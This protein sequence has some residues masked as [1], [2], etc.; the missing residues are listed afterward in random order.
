MGRDTGRIKGI[1]VSQKARL[2]IQM[3][4]VRSVVRRSG[5]IK[6][7]NIKFSSMDVIKDPR[8]H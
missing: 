2:S 3:C 7:N 8:K 5:N 6:K 4:I 1:L